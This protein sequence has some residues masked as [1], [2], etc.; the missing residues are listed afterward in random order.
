M[1]GYDR[2]YDKD[3]PA[4]SH[5]MPTGPSG[6]GSV[7][8]LVLDDKVPREYLVERRDLADRLLTFK[9]E[10]EPAGLREARLAAE[11]TRLTEKP[12]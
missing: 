1:S 8:W 6:R 10:V 7:I 4:R 3:D 2:V 12:R 9:D 5:I 11:E